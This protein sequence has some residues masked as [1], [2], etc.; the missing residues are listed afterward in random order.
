MP[1]LGPRAKRQRNANL[2]KSAWHHYMKAHIH[3]APMAVLAGR[4]KAMTRE[5]QERWRAPP[6]SAG[7]GG[8][9]AGLLAQA[10]AA[11]VPWPG[12]GDGFFP[13]SKEALGNVPECVH[14]KD[15]AWKRRIGVG[16]VRPC[17]AVN[18]PVRHLCEHKWG[19]G[20]CSE[21][22]EDREK[23]GLTRWHHRFATW[24]AMSKPPK[25]A[26]CEWWP[27]LPLFWMGH[28]DP[29]APAVSDSDPRGLLMLL[30]HTG[31]A[32]SLQLFFTGRVHRPEIGSTVGFD[33][34][35]MEQ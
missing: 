9:G 8:G 2:A 6:N 5:E 7:D 20:L 26:A 33:G 15:A 4:W 29:M 19:E 21:I 17:R 16:P 28:V 35:M 18:A 34:M 13:I 11:E 32:P 10:P 27:L 22:M 24:A 30:V 1:V 23:A 14:Q 3:T 31:Y 25:P 12:V